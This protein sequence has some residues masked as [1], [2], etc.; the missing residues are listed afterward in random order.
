MAARK[1]QYRAA[2]TVTGPR[3]R[4]TDTLKPG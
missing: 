3:F 2:A 4:F 1:R